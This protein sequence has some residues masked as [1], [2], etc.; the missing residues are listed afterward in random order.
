MSVGGKSYYV[1]SL[2]AEGGFGSVYTVVPEEAL[3]RDKEGRVV[4]RAEGG[5]AKKLVLKHMFAGSPELVAQLS[6]E[7]KLMQQLNG[8]PNVV[9]VMGAECRRKGEGADIFVLMEMCPG[10]HLLARMNQLRESK[11]TLSLAKML[12]IFLQIVRP[13]AHMHSFSPP[14]AHRDIKVRLPALARTRVCAVTS[15]PHPIGE[16]RARAQLTSLLRCPPPLCPFSCASAPLSSRM[17]S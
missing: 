5:A 4:V 9:A 1:E 6:A 10:G 12:E 16:T 13:I 17:S 14:I 3:E 15:S 2:L 11:R 8:H 7:V